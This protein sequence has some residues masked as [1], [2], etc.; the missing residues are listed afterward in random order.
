MV[1][2]KKRNLTPSVPSIKVDAIVSADA[3]ENLKPAPDIFLAASRILNVPPMREKQ[4]FVTVV[5]SRRVLSD[6]LIPGHNTESAKVS[7]QQLK[8]AIYA[9]LFDINVP[10]VC[11]I[12]QMTLVTLVLIVALS[13]KALLGAAGPAPEQVLDTSGK[14]VRARSSYYIVPASLI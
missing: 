14:I 3:F 11:A 13:T 12:N 1:V 4:P 10:V 6:N 9:S 2:A 8:E 5:F 7:R